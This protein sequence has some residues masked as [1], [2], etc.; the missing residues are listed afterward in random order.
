MGWTAALMVT[1]LIL[2]SAVGY[3]VGIAGQDTV[4]ETNNQNDSQEPT[5]ID[6]PP[7]VTM[8]EAIHDYGVTAFTIEGGVHDENPSSTVVHV[9]LI[10]PIDETR[11]GPWM[12]F[13]GSDG[14]WSGVLPISMPGEWTTS[15]YAQDAS[16]QVSQT[17]Y[18]SA[19]M[20]LPVEAA[21]ELTSSFALN[22]VNSD[23]A[24]ITGIISHPF[25]STCEI[26]YQP[27]GQEPLNG[28]VTGVE[29]SIPIHYNA[30]NH[31]GEIV[32]DCGLFTDTRTVI[33]YAIPELYSE[34]PDAD[35]DGIPDNEDNCDNTPQGEPVY[36]DGCSDSERDDDQDGISNADDDCTDTPLGESV[37]SV[38]CSGSQKDEDNDSVNNNLDACANTPEGESVDSSGCSESQK[39]DDNDGVVNSL[40]NCPNTPTGETVDEVG[41]TV[42]S[43]GGTDPTPMKILALH[44]GGETA[45]GLESQQGMQDLMDALPEFEFIF[46]SAP[47]SNNVWIRDPPGGKGEPTTDP[48]WADTSISYLD[49]MVIDEGPFYALLG[50]SQ[51]AAMIPVY[52]ANSDNSF[53]RVMMYNGY[54]PT[55]HEGLI[56]TI[57][58]VEPFTTPAMVFSGEN[59]D[60]FKDLAPA[61]AEKFAGSIDLHS[62]TAGH[63]LPY[64][65]D[66][67]F[68]SILTFI[69][70]GIA[71]YDPTDSWVCVDGQGPWV[72]D[73]NGDGNSYTSNNNGV[74]S[75]GGSGS[76]P[77]FQC[78]VTVTVQNGEM[79][80]ESNGIPNH[81]FLSTRGCCAPEKD[82]TAYI[83]LTPENDTTG[84]HTT[85][86]CPASA[87]RWEC[88]PDRGAVAIGV[89]GVPIFGPE[90]GP[91]GDAV[92]LHFDYFSE[93][94]QPIELG[95]CAG[96]SAGSGGYHYH[97]DANCIYWVPGAGEEMEDYDLSL[98]PGDSHSPIVGWAFDG[99]PIYGMYGYGSDDGSIRAITSSYAI[100]RTQEGGDQ[101][102]NG[103]DDW[104][105]V[106]GL[107]DLD[108]C[109]GRFGPTP[110][111]P[112][113]I[114]HYVSTPLSGSPTLV[115][116]TNGDQV[117]M[118]GFPYFL[119]CYHGVADLDSQSV[120]GGQGGPP[121]GGGGGAP[122]QNGIEY[123]Y[124]FMP[125]N[126]DWTPPNGGMEIPAPTLME[127][128]QSLVFFAFI[129]SI[130]VKSKSQS[131]QTTSGIQS[132]TKSVS[133]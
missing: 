81:D 21:A 3:M 53:N 57:E 65:D 103:I 102:Y 18:S 133:V 2:A 92:A 132:R 14:R 55:S 54:L 89:N 36:S 43:G 37:D 75:A 131:K 23:W 10:D 79:V 82:Y 78:E 67:H 8:D 16:G 97:Y 122:G 69:R 68:D 88:A 72:K 125:E 96:H 70:E 85:T 124:G 127:L 129:I 33:Q 64:E 120:G 77:W 128:A 63:H 35:Q 46:A 108:E 40:D 25:P 51:G 118:I 107:G 121:G 99:Y 101:G 9:E 20:P 86:N 27:Q 114:Y 98:I 13:A 106:D 28:Q 29:F 73:Y 41:C 5:I 71:P 93:D 123:G 12:F 91:G 83:T 42:N 49:Q 119:L 126:I 95:W 112:E 4:V 94:R 31:A 22:S 113:G 1:T 62:Q 7:L 56:D 87:G 26:S 115:T 76:G 48:D 44:G 17:V 30:T 24:D 109:N 39:D 50:Y 45:S 100:E 6:D 61:L 90:E 58:A 116:D 38:G 59:D 105:Y 104:N 19:I 80:V 32:A 52:L 110:E 60:W 47:E 11:Q 66:E 34:E 111:Y 130:S 84:G 74:S 117:G 15:A